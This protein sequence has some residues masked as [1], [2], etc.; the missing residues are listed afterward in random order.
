MFP[1]HPF[2]LWLLP[3]QLSLL[4]LQFIWKAESY[5]PMDLPSPLLSLWSWSVDVF[6]SPFQSPSYPL[7]VPAFSSPN[8]ARLW[9]FILRFPEYWPSPCQPYLHRPQV[10]NHCQFWTL[11]SM[12]ASVL[13]DQLHPALRGSASCTLCVLLF[14]IPSS[15]P[16]W[17]HTMCVKELVCLHSSSNLAMC[18]GKESI[19]MNGGILTPS[20]N[21]RAGRC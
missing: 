9:T 3:F 4:L 11:P 6:V 20:H 17:K 1:V 15:S 16:T 21:S 14:H 12:P 13:T 5:W 2:P 7:Q 10:P 18:I 8:V 19:P